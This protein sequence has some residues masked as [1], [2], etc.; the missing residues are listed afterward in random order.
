MPKLFFICGQCGYKSSKWLGKCPECESWN[1]FV[2]EYEAEPSK[3]SKSIVSTESVPVPLRLDD[4]QFSEKDRIWS[5][6]GELD[7]VLGGIVPGQ[8]VLLSGE[9]GIGK[10][11]LLLKLAGELSKT[12]NVFY[13]NGEESGTQVKQRALRIGVNSPGLFMYGE[14]NIN[15]VI[16][17]I[18][19]DKPGALI[20]DSIQTV[21]SPDYTSLP[22]SVV[23]IRECTYQIVSYCKES[24]IPLILVGHI[25]KSGSIAGPKI[26]EH[27]VD[28]VLFFECDARGYFRVLRSLKN[29]FF[30][31][32]EVGF[33]TMEENGLAGIENEATAFTQ[34]HSAR[35]SGISYFPYVEGNR[36]LP[37]EVQALCVPSQFNYPKR[38]SEG[39]DVNRLSMLIAI[40]EKKQKIVLAGHDVYLNITNGIKINDPALDL[41]VLSAVYSSFKDAD[42]F[43]D[44]A[45]FGEVGLTGEVRPVQKAEKRMAELARLGFN[46]F[47]VPYFPKGY[48]INASAQILPVKTIDEGILALY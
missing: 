21:Y 40:L 45:V 24:G 23:Q 30:S 37:V 7:R 43:L 16:K 46:R 44:T 15:E 48:K 6:I 11:T 31:T 41:A 8:A 38:N 22:G 9:P 33:F 36:V 35:V 25:T 13:V 26:V 27:M 10:S 14:N 28:T 3:K 39:F 47:L 19:K 1:S 2:E 5:G 4:I 20:I 29:R 18:K 32:E 34:L 42:A 12:R 17:Q